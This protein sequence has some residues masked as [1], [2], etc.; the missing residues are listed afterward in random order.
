MCN[1]ALTAAMGEESLEGVQSCGGMSNGI[2]R[3]DMKDFTCVG[4]TAPIA[5]ETY[6]D[7]N[8]CTSDRSTRGPS[9][10]IAGGLDDLLIRAAW[11]VSLTISMSHVQT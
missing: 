6:I 1:I 8:E 11:C 3:L 2:A 9:A 4:R 10:T 7:R 5:L